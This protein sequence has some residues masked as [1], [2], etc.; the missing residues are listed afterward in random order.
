MF[1]DLDW[2]TNASSPLS[3]SAELLVLLLVHTAIKGLDLSLMDL[4]LAVAG[5]DT[6]AY[7]R[8]IVTTLFGVVS[9]INGDIESKIANFSYPLYF[10]PPL[11]G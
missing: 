9:E 10:A 11:N 1:V 6:F 2:P 8:S 5:L 7:R 4:D 3:A